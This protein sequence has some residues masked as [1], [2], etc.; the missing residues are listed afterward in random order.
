MIAMTGYLIA[1]ALASAAPPPAAAAPDPAAAFSGL[2]TRW[3][4][5]NDEA[6]RA[7]ASRAVPAGP[8]GPLRAGSPELGARVGEIVRAGDCEE[9]ERVAR[10]AADFPL[11]EAVR[12]HCRRA[13]VQAV[14]IRR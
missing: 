4:G 12:A 2:F 11:V 7:E 8:A 3:T 13:A 14:S 1:S 6:L 9:G 5:V 10:A